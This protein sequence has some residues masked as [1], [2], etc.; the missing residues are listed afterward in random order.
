[1]S[2]GDDT[3][4]ASADEDQEFNYLLN[5]TVVSFL[6]TG[7]GNCAFGPRYT[8]GF[9]EHF[10]DP[11]APGAGGAAGYDQGFS[12]PTI[13][14]AERLASSYRKAQAIW[15]ARVVCGYTGRDRTGAVCPVDRDE[16]Y[17]WLGRV[18]HLLEDLTVP[19]HVHDVRHDPAAILLGAPEPFEGFVGSEYERGAGADYRALATRAGRDYRYEALPGIDRQVAFSWTDVHPEPTPLFELFWYTAQRTQYYATGG[20]TFARPGDAGRY[21]RWTD[22][23]IAQFEPSLWDIDA[24]DPVGDPAAVSASLA[25]MSDVLVP[26]ALRAVAGLYR[27]FWHETHAL[28]L[29][30]SP[31]AIRLG[32]IL[33][34][35]LDSPSPENTGDLYLAASLPDGSVLLFD[36]TSWG[37]A[38]VPARAGITVGGSALSLFAGRLEGRIPPGTYTFYAVLVRAG[39][40]PR[41]MGNW[42]SNLARGSFAFSD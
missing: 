40:D 2:P 26:H 8:N 10:W 39:S 36:G 18:A 7:S 25:E 37:A 19:A 14:R 42:L 20:T 32:D 22:D 16:A 6:L 13:N 23:G 35:T 29:T 24:I 4:T 41:D 9:F 30:V 31:R 3:V 1:Y 12:D 15:D 28:D 27:L 33:T 11:D 5:C 17:Y 34:V 21:R 38:V